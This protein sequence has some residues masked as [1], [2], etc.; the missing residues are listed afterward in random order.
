[1][2]RWAASQA[3]SAMTVCTGSPSS[4]SAARLTSPACPGVSS[5]RA[6]CPSPSTSAWILVLSP[7]RERPRA[8]SPFFG[9]ACGM[10][11]GANDGRVQ[12]DLLEICILGQCREHLS[13]H[14][15][16]RPARKTS[17]YRVP[18]TELLGQ[19]PP[20]TPRPGNPQDGLHTGRP[21]R[22]DGYPQ[23]CGPGLPPYPGASLRSVPIDHPATTSVPCLS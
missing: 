2:I 14:A 17:E 15:R 8:C 1:M 3:V 4:R 18:Q 19:I 23:H 7:P 16:V 6:R 22:N 12:E 21:P 9:C 5:K 20:W 11:M 10:L 13:P